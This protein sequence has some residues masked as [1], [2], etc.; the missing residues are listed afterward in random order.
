MSDHLILFLLDLS[1]RT[2]RTHVFHYLRDTD[3][4]ACITVVLI[5]INKAS[6]AKHK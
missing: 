6:R 3:I 1:F 2:R 4:F 5:R